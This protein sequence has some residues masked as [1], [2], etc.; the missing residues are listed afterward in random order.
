MA[1]ST[2]FE[3]D[4]WKRVSRVEFQN[5][6]SRDISHSQRWIGVDWVSNRKTQKNKLGMSIKII[7]LLRQK[8]RKYGNPNHSNN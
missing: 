8:I 2:D 6:S 1:A 3:N 4:G 7:M 5:I